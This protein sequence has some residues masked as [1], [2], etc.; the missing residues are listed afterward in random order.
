M[1]RELESLKGI[2]MIVVDELHLPNPR[3]TDYNSNPNPNFNP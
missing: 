3:A 2:D 1:H